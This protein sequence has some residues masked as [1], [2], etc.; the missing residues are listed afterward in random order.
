VILF[1]ILFFGFLVDFFF[2]W[3]DV[4]FFSDRPPGPPFFPGSHLLHTSLQVFFFSQLPGRVLV[5]EKENF[6]F[7]PI[8]PTRSGRT[9]RRLSG[10][11]LELFPLLVAQDDFLFSWDSFFQDQRL[12]R[13]RHSCLSSGKNFASKY[14]P[15]SST[16]QNL[17]F[18]APLFIFVAG[19][20]LFCGFPPFSPRLFLAL[21][22]LLGRAGRSS[23]P[24]KSGGGSRSP[25]PLL[26]GSAP[27]FGLS[28]LSRFLRFHARPAHDGSD[29][30]VV[31]KFP[32]CWRSPLAFF[33]LRGRLTPFSLSFPSS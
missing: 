29:F 2:R 12:P 7:P 1:P 24:P 27:S 13:H 5:R 19:D 4:S 8:R 32:F 28:W 6:P 11:F 9:I 17:E 22:Q 31:G 33:F 25:P 14:P 18:V 30:S 16:N 21:G 10:P 20:S 26:W 3:H 15:A 23:R